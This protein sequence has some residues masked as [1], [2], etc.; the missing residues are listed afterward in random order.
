MLEDSIVSMGVMVWP[1]VY[2]E[3][4]DAAAVGRRQS[5]Q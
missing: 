4:D 3:A 5:S 2:F 1:E